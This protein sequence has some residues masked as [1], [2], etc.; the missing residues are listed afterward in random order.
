MLVA[1]RL[2]LFALVLFPPSVFAADIQ[3]MGL[4]AWL[5]EGFRQPGLK[6]FSWYFPKRLK[7]LG[8]I[9]YLLAVLLCICFIELLNHEPPRL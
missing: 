7:T 6:W 3:K 8:P 1:L 4:R 5:A 9:I 2:T